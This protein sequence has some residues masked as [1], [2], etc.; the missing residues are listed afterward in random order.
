MSEPH[1]PP[2]PPAPPVVDRWPTRRPPSPRAPRPSTDY[3]DLKAA[4]DD[5]RASTARKGI[6]RSDCIA[7]QFGKVGEERFHLDFRAPFTAFHAFA[8][9]LCQFNL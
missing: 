9:V 6:A 3:A 7:L 1:A 8:V 2:T 4:V 5:E